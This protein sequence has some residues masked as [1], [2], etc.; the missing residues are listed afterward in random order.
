MQS[1]VR[2]R[3]KLKGLWVCPSHFTM[4]KIVSGITSALK[5]KLSL[6]ILNGDTP[7]RDNRFLKEHMRRNAHQISTSELGHLK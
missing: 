4:P 2:F 5:T 3:L 6:V 7:L 1:V